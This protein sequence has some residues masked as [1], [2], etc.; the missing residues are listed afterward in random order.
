MVRPPSQS[1]LLRLW[2]EHTTALIAV[3]QPDVHRHFASLESLHAFLCAQE[4][5]ETQ[6]R[7]WNATY[8]IPVEYS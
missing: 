3:G 1:F 4:D 8:G 6:T 5:E 2:R 7:D